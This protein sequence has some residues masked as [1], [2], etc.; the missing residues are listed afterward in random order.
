MQ[1]LALHEYHS[2]TEHHSVCCSTAVS[3]ELQ[4]FPEITSSIFSHSS[5]YPGGFISGPKVAS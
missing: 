5:L 3:P 2:D 1:D 4:M